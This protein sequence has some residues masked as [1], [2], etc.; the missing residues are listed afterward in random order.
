MVDPAYDPA[1]INDVLAA[2]DMR[3]TGVLVTHHHPDHVG[4]SMMGYSIEGLHELL[5]IAQ[6]PVHIQA[7]EAALVAKV[8]DLTDADLVSHRSGD[9]VMVGEI[10][11]ELIHTPGHTPGSQCFLID[12]A[13]VSGRH[14]VPRGLRP[15]RPARRRLGSALREPHPEVGQG[16]RRGRCSSPATS[17]RRNRQ[18]P[19]ARPADSTSSSGPGRSRSGCRCSAVPDWCRRHRVRTPDV[20]EESGNPQ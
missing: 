6:V 19:W 10:P 11:I 8:T 2:D 1:G 17:T 15:H 13:L 9:T 20:L 16:A 3:L 12:G 14:P 5:D 7:A 4:G 18:H